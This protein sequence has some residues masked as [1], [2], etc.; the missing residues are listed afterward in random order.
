MDKCFCMC[1]LI[2]TD[3]YDWLNS[4]LNIN[5]TDSWFHTFFY[6]EANY[7]GRFNLYNHNCPCD[8]CTDILFVTNAVI[9]HMSCVN[10]FLCASPG[11]W[12]TFY[13]N[14]KSQQILQ[15]FHRHIDSDNHKVTCIKR[16]IDYTAR[17]IC[18]FYN[19]LIGTCHKENE[20]SERPYLWPN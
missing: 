3:G 19:D 17:R 11:C 12:N 13:C 7:S 18:L 20:Y 6:H 10:G 8:F 9:H 4:K 5:R 16:S 1:T 15:M 2:R 14:V